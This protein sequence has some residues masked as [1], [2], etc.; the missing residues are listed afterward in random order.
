MIADIAVDVSHEGVDFIGEMMIG[1]GDLAEV[2]L[3]V[4]LMRQL[5]Y[6]L[7]HRFDRH[8]RILVTL[9]NQTR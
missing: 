4:A 7:L 9:Q 3:D 8:H 5:G 6:E 1:A 2:D